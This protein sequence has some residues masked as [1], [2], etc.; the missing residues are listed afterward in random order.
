M[1][2][3]VSMASNQLDHAAID[4]SILAAARREIARA[5]GLAAAAKM[6]PEARVARA[7]KAV[8]AREKKRR[9]ARKALKTKA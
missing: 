2:Y 9:K 1:R 3:R 8:Q 5:G 7:K 6:S 4:P